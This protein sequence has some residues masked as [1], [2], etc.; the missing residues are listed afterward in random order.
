MPVKPIPDGYHTAT[1][2][3]TVNDAAAAIEFYKRAFG[4]SELLRM[5]VPGGKVGHAEI[6]IGDSPIMLA[7]EHPDMG[8][9]GPQALGGT[10]V[11]IL[12]YVEDVD[13]VASQAIEAGATLL[14]PVKDQFYGDRS[15]T[16]ADPFGHVWTVAT[17]KEDLSLEE[18]NR[19][20]EAAM[21]QF[22]GAEK[23]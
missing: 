21:K 8:C 11:S 2:Y 19:R 12:L 6:K 14:R 13:A 5:E 23:S 20:A 10:P 17:H 15:G 22:A 7:D 16:F 3:L 4:A 18:I 1:P 9:R